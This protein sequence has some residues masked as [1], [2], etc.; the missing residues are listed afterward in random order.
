MTLRVVCR[1][2]GSTE[3]RSSECETR[4]GRIHIGVS[5]DPTDDRISLTVVDQHARATAKVSPRRIE[6]LTDML[7]AAV[8][9]KER[10][11]V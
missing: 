4:F 8:I 9:V 1:H 10:Q 7:H 3:H 5:D 2:C 6:E 11:R